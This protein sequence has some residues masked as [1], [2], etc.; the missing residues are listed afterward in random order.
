[1]FS[2]RTEWRPLRTLLTCEEKFSQCRHPFPLLRMTVIESTGSA[3]NLEEICGELVRQMRG[4]EGEMQVESLVSS[5]VQ[6]LALWQKRAVLL[7]LRKQ[8][9]AVGSVSAVIHRKVDRL[10]AQTYPQRPEKY[11]DWQAMWSHRIS[12]G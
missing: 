5:I 11:P 3:E 1:M 8:L 10:L 6:G 9:E 4:P 2:I 7:C 12:N